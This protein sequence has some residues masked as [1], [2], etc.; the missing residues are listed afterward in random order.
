MRAPIHSEKHIIQH[1][2]FAVAGGALTALTIVEG[3]KVLSKNLNFEVAEGAT[4][5]AVY[6]EYWLTS[7]D[8]AQG[9]MTFNLE[10]TTKQSV[11]MTYAQSID[12][13][14]DYFNRK[15]I[16]FMSEGLLP[17]NV[18]SGLPI[19]RGWFKIPKGKQRFGFGDILRVNISG[20]SNGVLACG[21]AIYK[22]YE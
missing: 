4:V 11:G 15:N 12:V 16:F 22:A 20:I 19:V 1:S 2:L 17:P 18:Q 7:D 5:K 10:K 9:S 8:A 6:L 3:V 14:N 13:M 21:L